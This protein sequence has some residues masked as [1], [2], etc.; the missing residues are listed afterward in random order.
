M[1]A[2]YGPGAA[3]GARDDGQLLGLGHLGGGHDRADAGPSTP[4]G[5]SVKRCLPASIVAAMWV[6]RKPGGVARMIRSAPLAMTPL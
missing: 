3:L 4:T 2:T 1:L 6:G 5:F